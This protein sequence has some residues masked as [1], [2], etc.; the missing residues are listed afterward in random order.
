MAR[1]F[2]TLE[3]KPTEVVRGEPYNIVLF[4][5]SGRIVTRV[6]TDTPFLKK[7]NF[8]A[9][10]PEAERDFFDEWSL[11]F[12]QRKLLLESTRGPVLVFNGLF[13]E[14]GLF[15]AL[16]FHTSRETLRGFWKN[17]F[18]RDVK[19]SPSLMEKTLPRKGGNEEDLFKII[20]SVGTLD[21]I[22][23][24]GVTPLPMQD[25]GF[26]V[27]ALGRMICSLARCFG[28]A[29]SVREAQR[30]LLSESWAFS[31]PSFVAVMACF[32]SLTANSAVA[33]KAVIDIYE[34]DGRIFVRL[35]TELAYWRDKTSKAHRLEYPELKECERIAERH[36][37]FLNVVV[38]R[39]EEGAAL[40]VLFS[41][42]YADA[43]F[44]GLKHP[45]DFNG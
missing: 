41:P 12:G 14:T 44:F 36:D 25:G 3:D 15:A 20:E 43:S 6:G 18:W 30:V 38:K 45:L 31:L 40:T 37:L 5:A 26:L 33:D 21:P 32:V 4:D 24:S 23:S 29:V 1:E 22:F 19:I 28:C 2:L 7:N 16:L 39:R 17:G 11:T 13:P 27:A 10:L 35:D 42:Q 9:L 34:E 8:F